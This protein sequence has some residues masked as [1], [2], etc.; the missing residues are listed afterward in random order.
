MKKT[1][2]QKHDNC[3]FPIWQHH[4]MKTKVFATF[5]ALFMSSGVAF[6]ATNDLAGLL[7]KGLFEEEANHNLAAAMRDYQAAIDGFDQ[8]RQLAATAVFRLGECLRKQGK[9]NEA[10]I[11]YAR[12]LREFPDQTNLVKLSSDYLGGAKTST[13]TAGAPDAKLQQMQTAY[14]ELKLKWTLADRE[15]ATVTDLGRQNWEIYFSTVKPDPVLAGL[16][17]DRTQAES[18]L[19]EQKGLGLGPNNPAYLAASASMREARDRVE[20]RAAELVWGLQQ[21]AQVLH[22]QGD[23]LAALLAQA[24]QGV[25]ASAAEASSAAQTTATSAEDEEVRKIRE[26]IRNSPDLI[27]A[28]IKGLTPLQSAV[29]SGNVAAG[30]LLLANGANVNGAGSSFPGSAPL[31]LAAV[32]GNK[33]MI[34]LL[35]AKGA[36][37][38]QADKFGQAKTPLFNAVEKGFKTTAEVLIAHKA[39]VNARLDNGW[40]PLHEAAADGFTAVAE[41]LIANGAIIGAT[42]DMDNTPLAVSARD[43]QPETAQLLLSNKADVN[44]QNNAGETPLFLAV[45]N[46]SVKVAP[47]LLAN[48]AAVN[49]RDKQGFTPLHLAVQYNYPDLVKLL[50]GNKADVNATTHIGISPLLFAVARTVVGP[51][52]ERYT[53]YPQGYSDPSASEVSKA[54]NL[55]KILLDS[56]ADPQARI[57]EG[58]GSWGPFVPGIHALDIAIEYG[59]SNSMELLLAGHADPNAFST[60]AQGR[61]LTPL[62]R[63]L[64]AGGNSVGEVKILLDHGAD[65]NLTDEAGTTPLSLAMRFSWPADVRAKLV[66]L[67]LDHHADPNRP[68]EQGLPPLAHTSAQEPEIRAALIKAGA[69]E[70]YLR[71]AGIFLA[72]KGTGLIGDPIFRKETPTNSVNHYT[73]MEVVA[74]AWNEVASPVDF[75]DFAHLVINRLKP[76]GGKA[77]IA[78]NLEEIFTNGDCSKDVPLEWGDVVQIPQ[79]DHLLNSAMPEPP[80]APAY[81]QD[82][83]TCLQR[84]VQIIVKGQTTKLRLLPAIAS[85]QM[86]GGQPSPAQFPRSRTSAPPGR[87]PGTLTN[88]GTAEAAPV[89]KTLYTFL[90][91]EVVHQ[92]NVLLLSSDL[93]RVKVTRNGVEML[94]NLDE[95]ASR[96]GR[97]GGGG[98]GGTGGGAGGGGVGRGGRG[99]L[100][101]NNNSSYL[102]LRDGD[103][104]EIP[105]R[106]PNAPAGK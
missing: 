40:T 42:D 93:S 33:A 58:G 44:V 67:L 17:R 63:V 12:V 29:Q 45:K 18:H 83:T 31:S 101:S 80:L 11:Q 104:I 51:G 35:L 16:L 24:G 73:L 30:E 98:G 53:T 10:G 68:D 26:M 43:N 78:V 87:S 37:V 34:E 32:S 90:L 71:L 19:N 57:K 81:I 82:L 48:K 88:E 55:M 84:Q 39:N 75:P 64:N 99:G 66:Q 62:S 25:A 52:G 72:Q 7:Q 77:E 54:T 100:G 41:L 94:Y 8:D 92:A 96:G 27:N 3:L 20:T 22:N 28:P 49:A 76:G 91:R 65:P 47:L 9:T 15:V 86:V 97:N 14:D 1:I 4:T 95:P 85:Q 38:N 61:V 13:L 21:Q 2:L 56:G 103:I 6:A 5:A 106:D 36:D 89:E 50:L 59:R 46:N 79:R 70:D 105:E 69:N 60:N 23:A 74:Q 102:W